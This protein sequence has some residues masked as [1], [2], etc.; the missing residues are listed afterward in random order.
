VSLLVAVLIWA[1]VARDPVAEIAIAVPIEFHHVPEDLEISSESLPEAQIRVRGAA[2]TVRDLSK[3]EVHAVID[4]ANA[5]PGEKTYDL[6]T[7]QVSVPDGVDVVQIIPSMIRIN[8][9]RRAQKQVPVRPRVIGTF[10]SGR[11]LGKVQAEPSLVTVVGPE[12]RVNA[13]DNAITD[14]VDASGVVDQATFTTNVYVPDPLVRVARPM[15]VR[16]TVTTTR[17]ERR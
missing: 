4:L 1:A 17:S 7:R 8:F 12:K 6:T 2:S 14:P 11:H 9:D 15:P 10:A 16:V 3:G 13:I 5:K